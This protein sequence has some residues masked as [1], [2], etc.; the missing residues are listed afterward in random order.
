M[1][2]SSL[3]FSLIF[4]HTLTFAH[5]DYSD[6]FWGISPALL[7]VVCIILIAVAGVI[8]QVRRWKTEEN[9]ENQK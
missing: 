2:I 5:G 6:D 3:F 9:K 4:I 7:A 1:K 8:V